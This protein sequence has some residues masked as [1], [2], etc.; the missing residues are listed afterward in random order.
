[1]VQLLTPSAVGM[2][3]RK[4][5]MAMVRAGPTTVAKPQDADEMKT[6]TPI[7]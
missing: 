2:P 7:K 6:G 5:K 3:D 4:S 1:M